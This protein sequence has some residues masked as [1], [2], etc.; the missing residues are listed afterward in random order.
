MKKYVVTGGA[1]FIGS[2]IVEHLT[3]E[4]NEVVVLDNLRTGFKKNLEGFNVSYHNVDIRQAEDVMKH[5]EGADAVFNLAALVSVPESLEKINECISINTL[6]TINILDAARK[7]GNC[8]VVLSSSAANYGN[9][10]VSPKIETMTPEPLTPYSITKLDGEYYLDMYRNEFK[11]PTT[12]LR[13]F[14][15]FGPRQ[16]PKSAY[17][18]VVPIFIIN[19]L[20]NKPLI[21]YGDGEQTRDFIYV[22][23]VV[24]ANIFAS[25]QGKGVYN[26]ALGQSTSVK[27]LAE[28]I[29]KITNSKS[30]IQFLETR[31]GDI[32]HS[33]ANPNKFNELGFKPK[34]TIEDGLS[35]TIKFYDRELSSKILM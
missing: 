15:V 4:G 18:A 26:V 11:V 19:A 35:E 29:I 16:N 17:A 21:I 28:H 20:Q 33:M 1:G 5:V 32:K 31:S 22:K 7:T 8:K 34:W 12:S 30:K 2:H 24:A 10:P 14:N 23:D 25:Q 27:Q 13:Y 9:N 6:G 3:K